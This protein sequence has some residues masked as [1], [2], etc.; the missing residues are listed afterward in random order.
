M[1]KIWVNENL[2]PTKIRPFVKFILKF[3]LLIWFIREWKKNMILTRR[4]K[5]QK[6][7]TLGND[8]DDT[9]TES[10]SKLN[11]IVFYEDT[12]TVAVANLLF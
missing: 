6:K 7:T 8:S 12:L 2:R 4:K 11:K 10:V 1:T 5:T 3:T 9:I